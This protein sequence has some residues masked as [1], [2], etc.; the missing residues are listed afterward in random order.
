V[1]Q[2]EIAVSLVFPVALTKSL[3]VVLK[4]PR[5]SKICHYIGDSNFIFF[6]SRRM[7]KAHKSNGRTKGPKNKSTVDRQKLGFI[8]DE[9]DAAM[10]GNEEVGVDALKECLAVSEGAMEYYR[11]LG[12]GGQPNKDKAKGRQCE[13]DLNINEDLQWKAYGEWHDRRVYCAKELAKYQSPTVRAMSPE[14]Q[15]KKLELINDQRIVENK[16]NYAPGE[17]CAA[18]ARLIAA[19]RTVK[20]PTGPKLPTG[21]YE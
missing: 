19:P 17:L 15:L 14:E 6:R 5:W 7:A 12:M 2:K 11:P 21:E 3:D 16:E 8:A 4:I 10:A 9:N 20:L 18:Y 13:A 1:W